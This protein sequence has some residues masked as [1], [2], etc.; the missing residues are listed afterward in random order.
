MPTPQVPTVPLD[1]VQGIILRGYELLRAA[2]FLLLGL[3]D[4]AGARRWLQQLL[5]HVHSAKDRPTER[6]VNV[7]FTRA[8]LAVLV[9]LPDESWRG[10]SREFLEGMDT[11][12][13][14]R[15]LGDTGDSAP[16]KWRWGRS[17]DPHP[18][19]AVLMLYANDETG[20]EALQ[21]T[22]E[23]LLRDC[24]ITVLYPLSTAILT[25]RKEQFGFRDGIAQ[26]LVLGVNKE[27]PIHHKEPDNPGNQV[28]PGEFL[29]GFP[30]EY[31]RM[32]VSPTVP[33]PGGTGH[34][35]FGYCGSYLVF[36]QLRQD[37]RGFW[38]LMD[39]ATARPGQTEKEHADARTALAAKMVGRWPS[40][41]PL[42]LSPQGDNP[43]LED[44]DQYGFYGD[45]ALGAKVP[46][47]SHT[48]R[49]N[50]RDALEPGPEGKG[51]LAPEESL[52]VTKLHRMIRRGRPYG[53]PIAD[54][55]NPA[56]VLRTPPCPDE[57]E[58][59][60]HFLCFNANIARQF[61]FVQ[62]T[63]VNNPK[64]GGLYADNDPIMGQ[65]KPDQLS[66]A[67]TFTAQGE[68]V[69]RRLR[70]LPDFVQVRGGAYF[71]MPGL[72]ALKYLAGAAAELAAA[73]PQVSA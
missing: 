32:S 52:R 12:H 40:G 69:R 20:M 56:D 64:F 46:I 61:E 21:Q 58:C 29:L 41:A 62:Q 37:V 1:Q 9:D 15:V 25:G 66:A 47:G 31:D 57:E 18:V 19:H 53:K 44:A 68:P 13:R 49:A 35:D 55:M 26:P 65:R 17:D 30:N 60:L 28:K 67:D 39:R 3:G 22:H 72:E 5:P 43:K 33:S 51:R 27:P 71:F 8:G 36:R 34:L 11:P 50:P 4:R 16:S 63:W 7:A 10:F 6:A 48:R 59:G 23:A 42:A 54:S 24:G 14:Q 2:R 45:D 73:T 70:G 38:Q